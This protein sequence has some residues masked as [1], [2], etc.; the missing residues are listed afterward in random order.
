M[1]AG[2]ISREEKLKLKVLC[3]FL[4][5]E[6][7]DEIADFLRFKI[8][9]EDLFPIEENK[10]ENLFDYIVGC[11]KD[12]NKKRIFLSFTRLYDAYLNYKITKNK[13]NENQDISAFF[14]K[15]MNSIIIAPDA[16]NKISI[17]QYGRIDFTSNFYANEEFFSISRLVVLCDENKTILGLKLEYNNNKENTVKLYNQKNL[18]K[19][20]DLK[21]QTDYINDEIKDS[22]TH[23][24]GTFDQIVKFIGFKFSSGKTVYFGRPKGD[25]FLFGIYGKKVQYF[26]LNIGEK[27]IS[28]LE[29]IFTPNK[30][31]NRFIEYNQNDVNKIYNEEKKLIENTEKNYEQLRK[32]QILSPKKKSKFQGE[33]VEYNPI[34]AYPVQNILGNENDKATIINPEKIQR[35]YTLN[36]NPFLIMDDDNDNI[37][38]PNPFFQKEFKEKKKKSKGDRI[39]VCVGRKRN[40][41]D[42]LNYNNELKIK[43]TKSHGLKQNNFEELKEKLRKDLEQKKKINDLKEKVR[44]NIYDN[45]LNLCK[46]KVRKDIRI[47]LKQIIGDDDDI[48]NF[49]KQEE[50]EE[51]KIEKENEENKTD[52]EP[53]EKEEQKIEKENEE[54]KTDDNN[55]KKQEKNQMDAVNYLAE[56]L[57]LEEDELKKVIINLNKKDDNKNSKE[58]NDSKNEKEDIKEIE[59][60]AKEFDKIKDE[61]NSIVKVF[62]NMILINKLSKFKI[63]KTPKK[64]LEQFVEKEEEVDIDSI[65]KLSSNEDKSK[66]KE[67]EKEEEEK[68]KQDINQNLVKEIHIPKIKDEIFQEENNQENIDDFEILKYEEEKVNILI[69]SFYNN[70]N[71]KINI[72]KEQKPPK[73]LKIWK[74]EMFNE[75]KALGKKN[76][77]KIWLRPEEAGIK[78]YYIIKDKPDIKNIRQSPKIDDCYFLSALGAL[79]EKDKKNDI[80]KNLFLITERT[81]EKAY[82]IYFYINGVR[83]LILIDDFFAY[84]KDK[85]NLSLYYSSSFDKSE[86][87]VSLIEKAWAKLK[88]SYLNVSKSRALYAF[89]ALTGA[90]T[91]QYIIR[92]NKSEK[93]WKLLR[94]TKDYLICAGTKSD[95]SLVEMFL[96]KKGLEETHEY[97]LIEIIENEKERKVKLRDP[98]GIKFDRGIFTLDY[99]DFLDYFRLLEINFFKPDLVSIPINI[100]IEET[101]RFQ[102]IQIDNDYDNNEIYINLYQ[103]N[104][105]FSYIMLIKK[106][107]GKEGDEPNYIWVDSVTSL[108]DDNGY[109]KHIGMNKLKMEKGRYYICC[110]INYRFCDN[111]ENIH[112]YLLNIYSKKN[113]I[114]KVENVTE[115]IELN[116]KLKIFNKTIYNYINEKDDDDLTQYNKKKK[117][118]IHDIYLFNDEDL[119]PFDIFSFKNNGDKKVKIE[120]KIKQ[121]LK[122]KYY[123]YND[124]KAKE[125]DETLIKEIEPNKTIIFCVM[126]YKFYLESQKYLEYKLIN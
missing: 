100:S 34:F 12:T 112:D 41:F 87:W 119:F 6:R 99:E 120:F 107:E 1:E 66:S 105:I 82:G 36:P 125:S 52:D 8:C 109:D 103:K 16:N 21:L 60:K 32:T 9:L 42:S 28:R 2:L 39:T 54:N 18:Y 65:E 70:F 23:V 101:M 123:F 46:N 124:D 40:I 55:E 17:G 122:K 38:I 76:K 96:N 74:D 118:F 57:N 29:A 113:Q 4:I 14:N 115:K 48:D 116:E 114:L 20:L 19:A 3:D 30:N 13:P 44:D 69:K 67:E 35:E 78:N 59:E 56:K 84:F 62:K 64:V 51:Q 27:G 93:I 26:N 24:F 81:K 61:K 85:K 95:F 45:L 121:N 7:S 72:F 50:K 53:E 71:G 79:C 58:D 108:N 33:E 25:P 90:Y 104:A 68:N 80:V 102:I 22:I 86:L 94:N 97:T 117:G 91:R 63:K 11:F 77:K 111:N 10:L 92:K 106:I 49:K 73:K 75:E 98:Y 126:K 88:G 83:Q 5:R 15:F 110:D 47:A 37:F 31:Y 89:E 43:L